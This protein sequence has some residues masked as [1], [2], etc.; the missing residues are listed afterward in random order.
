MAMDPAK[1]VSHYDILQVTPQ[2]SDEDIKR[3]YRRLAMHH[4]PDRHPRNR[5]LA[6]LRFKLITEAYASLKTQ[7]HRARYN[8]T[9]PVKSAPA[10]NDN[11]H[12][13]SWLEQFAEIFRPA[14][15]P[16]KSRV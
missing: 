10:K 6:E 14:H 9:L 5:K 7:E 2:A 16:E 13:S 1:R 12:K 15:K 4:H 3:A 8:L 11:A